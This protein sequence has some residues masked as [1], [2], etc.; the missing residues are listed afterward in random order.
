MPANPILNYVNCLVL[1]FHQENGTI[2]T[3]FPT[4]HFRYHFSQVYFDPLSLTLT[5][6]IS[7][8]KENKNL[9][10]ISI[11][12]QGLLGLHIH[13]HRYIKNR[14]LPR[15][16]FRS[17]TLIQRWENVALAF[18]ALVDKVI[19]QQASLNVDANVFG[20]KSLNPSISVFAQQCRHDRRRFIISVP[21][22]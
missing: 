8:I 9:I 21:L 10:L 1:L 18:P 19:L 12:L 11:S 2:V 4:Y 15:E 22:K 17:S 3:L 5:Q 7:R 14:E 13:I 16:F 20:V 6:Q